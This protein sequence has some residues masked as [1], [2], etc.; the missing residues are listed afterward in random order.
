MYINKSTTERITDK[1]M[2]QKIEKAQNYHH[3]KYSDTITITYKKD[4][5]I[6]TETWTH[7][8]SNTIF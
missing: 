4:N 2:Q 6:E 5:N 8:N 1:Q 7:I 3:G